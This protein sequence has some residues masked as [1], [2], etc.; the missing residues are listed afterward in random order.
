MS[1]PSGERHM[2]HNTNISSRQH[3]GRIYMEFHMVL[4]DDFGFSKVRREPIRLE[5]FL[6]D[7]L[8]TCKLVVC[9]RFGVISHCFGGESQKI[10]INYV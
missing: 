7:A 9:P 5:R 1:L 2:A 6:C 10:V 8:Y 3:E 4:M